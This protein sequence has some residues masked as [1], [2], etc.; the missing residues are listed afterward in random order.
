MEALLPFPNKEMDMDCCHWTSMNSHLQMG[1]EFHAEDESEPSWSLAKTKLEASSQFLWEWMEDMNNYWTHSFESRASW[2]ASIY[3]WRSSSSRSQ[4]VVVKAVTLL[5][6]L[7]RLQN[8]WDKIKDLGFWAATRSG[9]ASFSVFDNTLVDDKGTIIAAAEKKIQ[10]N[11][12]KL[13]QRSYY[14]REKELSNN[15]WIETTRTS[16]R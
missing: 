7:K 10:R 5:M 6:M 8:W 2:R 14:R 9:G 1:W 15:V 12:R 4:G 16:C 11:W 13:L 3:K